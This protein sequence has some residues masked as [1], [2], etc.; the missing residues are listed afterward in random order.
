VA[1]SDDGEGEWG[2][3]GTKEAGEKDSE[4]ERGIKSGSWMHPRHDIRFGKTRPTNKYRHTDTN[5]LQITEIEIDRTLCLQLHTSSTGSEARQREVSW[6]FLIFPS[7]ST[8]DFGCELFN[9]CCCSFSPN[10]QYGV[11]SKFCFVGVCGIEV[12]AAKVGT[13]VISRVSVECN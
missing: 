11:F 8:F 3:K 7:H 1:T 2:M 5:T 12:T 4:K 13:G 6:L 10:V 9:T